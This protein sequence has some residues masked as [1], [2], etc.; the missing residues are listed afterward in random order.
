MPNFEKHQ[1]TGLRGPGLREYEAPEGLPI[2]RESTKIYKYM[3]VDS[4]ENKYISS[5]TDINNTC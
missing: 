2:K 1:E 4:H 3:I 5:F